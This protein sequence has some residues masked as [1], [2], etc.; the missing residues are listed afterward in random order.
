ALHNTEPVETR[1]GIDRHSLL[2]AFNNG[3]MQAWFQPK[4]A[5]SNGRIVAAE[6]L[7]RWLHPEHG[8][9]LPGVFLPVLIS[10]N[11]EEH[12]L[13]HMLEQAIIAQAAWRQQGYDIPV[14]INLPTHLLNSHD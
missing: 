13:W 12:L 14:S 4:K 5:L 2:N 11:L 1:P 10:F 7:V 6:A 3:E 9:L 8:M